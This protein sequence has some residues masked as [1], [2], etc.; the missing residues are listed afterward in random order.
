MAD[1]GGKDALAFDLDDRHIAAFEAAVAGLRERGQTA[2]E[3]IGRH[4]FPLDD[5]AEDVRAWRHEVTEPHLKRHLIRLW[6]MDWD[7]RPTLEG[8]AIPQG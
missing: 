6:L 3:D 8:G 4:D 5:I 7:G 1:L 2:F